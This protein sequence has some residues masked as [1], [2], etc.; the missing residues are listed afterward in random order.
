M[1][2]KV[3]RTLYLKTV[4]F[5]SRGKQGYEPPAIHDLLTQVSNK[6]VT[7]GDRLFE[8]KV[9]DDDNYMHC[10][11]NNF[12]K[13]KNGV[14][15]FEFCSYVPGMILPQL[16]PDPSV[17]NAVH[18]YNPIP[19]PD[20]EKNSEL[21]HVAEVLAFGSSMIIENVPGMGGLALLSQYIT[22]MARRFVDEKHYSVKLVDLVSD[23]LKKRIESAGGV[24]AMTLKVAHNGND[25]FKFSRVMNPAKK[26]VPNTSVLTVTWDGKSSGVLDENAVLQAF[27]EATDEDPDIDGIIIKLKDGTSINGT[28]RYKVKRSVEVD[29][30]VGRNPNRQQIRSELKRYLMELMDVDL[31]GNRTLDE[32]GNFIR[33]TS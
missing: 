19:S 1:K 13:A 24:E 3:K 14:V 7:V 28:S 33:L 23:D 22:E 17:E 11:M 6:A 21:V 4:K 32:N 31:N 26:L 30:T 20:G 16:Q 25:D 18:T 2:G 15:T 29:E 5:L 27:D 10:F 9:G 8:K 12:R